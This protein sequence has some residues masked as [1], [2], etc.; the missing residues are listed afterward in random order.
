[1]IIQFYFK[2]FKQFSISTHF[3]SIWPINRT[4]SGATTT[5]RILRIPQ[6]SNITGTSPSDWLMSYP[7]YSLGEFH[8]SAEKQSVYCATT[9]D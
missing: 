8:L 3:S 7:E 1:M 2:Q 5:E 9:V 4:L 6:S